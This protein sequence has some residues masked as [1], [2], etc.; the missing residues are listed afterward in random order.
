MVSGFASEHESN[1]YGSNRKIRR[2]FICKYSTS[3]Q[4][5]TQA[6]LSYHAESKKMIRVGY[7]VFGKKM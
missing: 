2:F 4:V 5:I 7:L 6:Y 3:Q 1:R